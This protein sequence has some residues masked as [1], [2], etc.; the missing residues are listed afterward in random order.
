MRWFHSDGFAMQG[1][2]LEEDQIAPNEYTGPNAA[3]FEKAERSLRALFDQ[4]KAAQEL[5]FAMALSPEMRGMQDAG[6]NTAHEAVRAYDEFMGLLETT[7]AG[8]SIRVRVALMFYAHLSEGS[9]FYEIPKK[10]LLT[11]EGKGNNIYPFRGLVSRHNRTGA[12]MAPNANAI[13][14]DLIGHASELGFAELAEVLRDAFDPDVRNAIAHADY[15]IWA[16]GLRLRRRNGGHPRV[17]PWEEFEPL[18]NRG[19]QLFQIIRHLAD[20]YVRQ[21]D[22]PKRIRAR[23]HE[24]EAEFNYTIF[25]DPKKDVFGFTTGKYDPDEDI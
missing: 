20:E 14:R 2:P 4:A 19:L 22:P 11:T 18:I 21:Y 23:L 24:R 8:S 25:F 17:I 9:G 3:Y 6:W 7:T 15:I 5:H 16:D 1:L 12:I 13:M 10:M